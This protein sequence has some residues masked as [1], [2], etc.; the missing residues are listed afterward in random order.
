[1]EEGEERRVRAA[2]CCH[3][4]ADLLSAPPSSSLG[5]FFPLHPSFIIAASRNL[6][7][8]GQTL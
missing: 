5:F 2:Q 8:R 7:N 3:C 1:M 4:S 6:D